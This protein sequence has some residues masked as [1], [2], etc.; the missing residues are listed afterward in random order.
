MKTW[1]EE[2]TNS[3]FMRVREFTNQIQELGEI[4]SDKEMTTIVL[5]S[6]LEE[7]E[8]FTSSIYGNKKTTL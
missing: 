2:A 1:K 5:N 6:L 3:Y 8:N 4:I 7:W